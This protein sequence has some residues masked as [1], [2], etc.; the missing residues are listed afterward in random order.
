MEIKVLISRYAKY[1]GG[2]TALVDGERRLTFTEVNERTN[3]LANGLLGLGVK[4]GDKVAFQGDN[5]F[6]FIEIWFAKYKIGAVDVVFSPRLSPDELAFRAK[7]SELNTLIVA[8]DQLSKIPPRSELGGVKNL[9]ALSSAPAGWLDYEA[10]IAASSAEEPETEVSGEELGH[11]VYTAGTTGLPKGI[12]LRR[13]SYLSITRNILLDMIPGLNK[14]DI[15]LGLQPM[16]HA[17]GT[18]ILPCWIRGATHIITSDY[19]AE[20]V[21]P[22][23]ERERVTIVKTVP[24]LINRYIAHPDVRKYDFSSV[25][26]IIYGASPMS[27]EKLKQAIQIFG[28]I[29]SQNYGQSEAPMTICYL[30]REDHITEGKPQEVARL[31]SVGRPYTMVEAKIVDEKGREVPQGEIGEICVRGDHTMTGYFK[32]SEETK[33]TLKEGWVYTGDVG[34]MDKDGYIFLVDRKKELIIT[35]GFNV[36]PAEVEQVLHRHP[37]VLEACVFGIP[38]EKWGRQ[39]KQ[40]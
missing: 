29:F 26:H 27:V 14:N 39:L 15:F 36:A 9:I 22:L 31:A 5:C 21:F 32:R 40:P 16:Y 18:F 7:D 38:D 11:I 34:K 37:A 30:K 20:S 6:Q 2:K 8:E 24:T 4:K 3:R 19:R 28:P 17:V 33:E 23:I 1:Y 10:L 13:S 25:Q 12:M 35:G